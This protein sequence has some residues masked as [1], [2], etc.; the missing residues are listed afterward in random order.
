MPSRMA[1]RVSRIASCAASTSLIFQKL[2]KERL[3][4]VKLFQGSSILERTAC[5]IFHPIGTSHHFGSRRFDDC[6]WNAFH[7]AVETST[8]EF[9]S[10]L[11]RH[12]KVN[13]SPLVCRLVSCAFGGQRVW[14]PIVLR[15]SQPPAAST[16]TISSKVGASTSQLRQRDGHLA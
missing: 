2:V 15:V 8:V 11:W 13:S 4:A 6:L 16:G 10:A 3:N 12:R 1:C 7:C 14:L 9:L 5:Q